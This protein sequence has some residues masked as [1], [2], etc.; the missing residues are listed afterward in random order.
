MP[1][2]RGEIVRERGSVGGQGH[3]WARLGHREK[4]A[5]RGKEKPTQ[6]GLW[7]RISKQVARARFHRSSCGPERRAPTGGR[8]TTATTV[9]GGRVPRTRAPEGIQSKSRGTGA[10]SQ[11]PGGAR[12]NE[13]RP[14]R[15]RRGAGSGSPGTPEPG[16][17]C[18]G[19]R[20][21]TQISK[22][23]GGCERRNKAGGQW[24]ASPVADPGQETRPRERNK[25]GNTRRDNTRPRLGLEA[26]REKPREAKN[27]DAKEPG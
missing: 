4:S 24:S 12:G 26:A 11:T 21:T 10:Q 22:V 2:E 15:R 19:G 5:R 6:G 1:A 13:G 16:K 17:I 20:E 9:R 3:A 7:A 27:A 8:E 14:R 23:P 18:T 25:G